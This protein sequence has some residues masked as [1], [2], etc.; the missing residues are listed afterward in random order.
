MKT[1]LFDAG[2]LYTEIW[3]CVG[4]GGLRSRVQWFFN[5]PEHTCILNSRMKQRV[6]N[7]VKIST[8]IIPL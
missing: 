5:C 1:I 8:R 2:D 3:G 6:I 4:Q 7:G